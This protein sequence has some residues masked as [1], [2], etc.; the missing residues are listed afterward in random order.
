MKKR[1]TVLDR[2]ED[3][4]IE[5]ALDPDWPREKLTN[6]LRQLRDERKRLTEELAAGEQ[7]VTEAHTNATRVLDYLEDP[8]EGYQ[9]SGT[10]AKTAI[11]RSLFH[12]LYLDVR[13]EIVAYV[14]SDELTDAF[15][16]VV[17][18]R[19]SWQARNA[20]GGVGV[21]ALHRTAVRAQKQ[22]QRPCS[23]RCR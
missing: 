14:A 10:R 21:Q 12:R 17:E 16:T 22:R 6:K 11:N 18:L 19:R 5:L 2:Q 8:Y 3:R 20:T 9:R 23:G 15:K 7:L 13:D 4:Y 1:L